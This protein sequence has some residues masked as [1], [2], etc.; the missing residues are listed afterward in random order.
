MQ[1]LEQ[2]LKAIDNAIPKYHLVHPATSRS[3]VGWHIEHSLL[4]IDAIIHTA[5]KSDPNNYKWK[6]NF[7]RTL[8][9]TI[10]KIPRGRAQAPK[11]VQPQTEIDI[12]TL[13]AHIISTTKNLKKLDNLKA[14]NYFEHPFFGKLNLKPTIKFLTIHTKH[15]LDIINDII[16][17]R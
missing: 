4:T 5:E 7:K 15:H 1:Q 11:R 14:N 2:L 16:K 6:F 17:S 10:N 9:F 13:Q 8:V 3:S 12:E